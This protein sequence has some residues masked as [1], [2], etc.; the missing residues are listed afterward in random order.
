MV[1]IKKFELPKKCIYQVYILYNNHSYYFVGFLKKN[2]HELNSFQYEWES[3]S[4][5]DVNILF[6]VFN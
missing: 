5:N 4:V 1:V 3:T 2:Q 6:G